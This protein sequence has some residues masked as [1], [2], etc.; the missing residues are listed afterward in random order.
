MKLF[1]G[2]APRE[3]GPLEIAV[4]FAQTFLQ[5]GGYGRDFEDGIMLDLTPIP[6]YDL[7]GEITELHKIWSSIWGRVYGV[8]SPEE[9]SNVY[10]KNIW[11]WSD[12]SEE[13]DREQQQVLNTDI[14]EIN[15]Q[16]LQWSPEMVG[17]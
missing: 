13:Q 4:L 5:N 8:H 1:G 17:L 12:D 6:Y 14:S 10:E 11:A 2:T 15:E 9:A 7:S 16:D 3:F